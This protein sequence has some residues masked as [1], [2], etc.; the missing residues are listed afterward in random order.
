MFLN[1][2]QELDYFGS[3][4]DVAVVSVKEFTT[5]E[6][7]SHVVG[8][9]MVK[10]PVDQIIEDVIVITDTEY[11]SKD[12]TDLYRYNFTVAIA[13]VL[14]DRQIVF[15]RDCWFSE[16]FL[17]YRGPNAFGK[18][19]TFRVSGI[20]SPTG[21]KDDNCHGCHLLH[22]PYTCGNAIVALRDCRPSR[23]DASS[24]GSRVKQACRSRHI[25]MY[26]IMLY[27]SRLT[28]YE[29]DICR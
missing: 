26:V 11:M 22:R 28:D 20:P 7:R 13:F 18:I 29:E 9:G 5:N 10:T 6:I 24:T 8:G 16:D 3:I 27:N 25:D 23:S 19:K 17:I 12:G 2:T 14:S 21:A 15:E 1:E 4:D